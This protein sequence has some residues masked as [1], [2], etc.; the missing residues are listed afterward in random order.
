MKELKNFDFRRL[1]KDWPGIVKNIHILHDITPIMI[2]AHA[3][4]GESRIVAYNRLIF[5]K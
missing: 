1:W 2:L 5:I 4:Y 3:S